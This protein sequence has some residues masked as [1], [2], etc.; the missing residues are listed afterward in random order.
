MHTKITLMHMILSG[1]LL[2]A[3]GGRAWSILRRKGSWKPLMGWIAI[4]VLAYGGFIAL[5]AGPGAKVLDRLPEVAFV[6]IVA[7]LALAMVLGLFELGF[8]AL[9]GPFPDLPGGV[10][11]VNIS[12]RR[13]HPWMGSAAA[14]LI[15]AGALRICP[16]AWHDNLL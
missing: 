10:V 16:N 12:R 4:A 15:M 7:A 5:I 8:R 6:T 11:C 1:L 9:D 3:V 14:V 13:L 2:A